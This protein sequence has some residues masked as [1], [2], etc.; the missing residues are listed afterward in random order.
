MGQYFDAA[1]GVTYSQQSVLG[2]GALVLVFLVIPIGRYI[3]K[4][5]ITVGLKCE[6]N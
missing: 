3:W 4:F 2:Y 5:V 6:Y 1:T